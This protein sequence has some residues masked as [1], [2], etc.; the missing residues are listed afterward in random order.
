MTD[1]VVVGGDEPTHVQ[2][3]RGEPDDIELAALVAGLAAAVGGMADDSPVPGPSAWMDRSRA[4]RARFVA[5]APPAPTAD[6]WR[7]S[8][9]G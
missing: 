7:W 1:D 5:A 3:V 6:A 2:V 9:R 8:L 4:M